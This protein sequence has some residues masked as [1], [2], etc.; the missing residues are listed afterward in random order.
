[1]SVTTLIIVHTV[2]LFRD[3]L[4]YA[5]S[6]TPEYRVIGEA[7]NGQQAI[8]LVDQADPDLVVMDIDLPGVHG[9][10]VA[11][12]IKRSHP[13]IGIILFGPTN[14]GATVVKAIRAG[15][16]AMVPPNIEFVDLLA[17]LHQ[18]RRGEY[19]I[20]DLVLTSPEVAATVLE[21]FRQ[22]VGDGDVQTVFSPLSA[23]ELEV[24]ELV[25]A[26]RTNREIA[27]QLDISN[28]TVK[29]H[30]SSILRKLA[31]NDRTQAVVYAMRRGWIKV[32]L[33]DGL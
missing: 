31:V 19:P 29:N 30:I 10:E 32:V 23:R 9:L 17:T 12:V 6:S 25:A 26:G 33:P 27:A 16:S 5:L 15:V 28:Q 14:D 4:C 21:A 7:S 20:N 1:M 11:R 22:M 13:H 3:G 2:S 8:Q 18:V 24:L